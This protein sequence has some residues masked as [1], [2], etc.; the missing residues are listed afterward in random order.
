[1]VSA[2]ILYSV[3]FITVFLLVTP[4]LSEASGVYREIYPQLMENDSLSLQ[5]YYD[6][7]CTAENKCP[8]FFSFLISFGGIYKSNGGL[9]GVQIALDEINRDES[10]LPGYTLHYTLHDSNVSYQ[11]YVAILC[12]SLMHPGA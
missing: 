1:M 7:D 10:I 8:L 4:S 12:Y 3:H 5:H 9:P 11:T 6:R 2:G